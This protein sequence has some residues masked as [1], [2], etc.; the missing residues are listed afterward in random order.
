[1]KQKD[2]T[3]S[4]ILRCIGLGTTIK[5]KQ[6]SIIA[7][8]LGVIDGVLVR[9]SRLVIPEILRPQVLDLAHE[10]HP[11]IVK[12]KSRLRSKVWWPGIDRSAERAVKTCQLCQ[13]VGLP[14]RPAEMSRRQLPEGP[15]QD[16][17]MDF[18]GPLRSNE[19]IC[20]VIDY[21]SRFPEI[22]VMKTITAAKTIEFLKELFARHGIPYSITCDNGPQFI[23]S[24][25]ESFC[26][27]MGVKLFKVT[28]LW[29]QAN[30]EIERLNRCIQKIIN[31]SKL[32]D[33]D[34]KNDLHEFLLMYRS[35]AHAVTNLSPAELLFNRKLKDK[36][37]SIREYVEADELR[38]RDFLKKE[39]GKIY[40]DYSR[41][42][43]DHN[44][45]IGESVLIKRT[46]EKNKGPTYEKDAG[47][48]VAVNGSEVTVQTPT[49]TVR[50]NV[51]HVKREEVSTTL[52]V[53]ATKGAQFTVPSIEPL[54][55][56][57]RTPKPKE[58]GPDFVTKF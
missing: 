44:L 29:P 48:V 3:L 27:N 16:L 12:M 4:S 14:P 21:Y 49:H 25:L 56:S 13:R 18:K 22:K 45:N 17:A 26:Q 38:E 19:Y 47:Q 42:A 23:S 57:E 11:G 32:A 46:A 9:G 35:T 1:M 15:W 10:G 54:R 6:Y 41:R 31:I 51:A 50:R 34:W 2:A 8:E 43:L 5:E 7:D 37:P 20:G 24:E 36:L 58:W 55:H 52:P 33:S 40:S 53:E 28:P 39:K 30:G